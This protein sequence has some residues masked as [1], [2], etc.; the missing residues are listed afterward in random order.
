MKIL[1]SDGREMASI[2]LR[3]DK[4][5]GTCDPAIRSCGMLVE[6]PKCEISLTRDPASGGLLLNLGLP[7]LMGGSILLEKDDVRQV[8]S[9]MN[10]DAVKFMI[11]AFM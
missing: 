2:D 11:Q 5:A 4:G 9:L 7:E 8:K 3:V 10:K 6:G 1:T